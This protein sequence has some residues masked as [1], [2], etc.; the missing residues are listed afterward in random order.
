MGISLVSIVTHVRAG[1]P[2]HSAPAASAPVPEAA[3]P[4]A[5]GSLSRDAASA[6]GMLAAGTPVIPTGS[7]TTARPGT[8][9]ISS[10][11]V[12]ATATMSV[13]AHSSLHP[14]QFIAM[15]R[16][17]GPGWL[18]SDGTKSTR[19]PDGRV[20]WSYG[21]TLI[22]TAREGRVTRLDGFLRNSLV[23]QDGAKRTTI[24][25][26]DAA[27]KPSA[28]ILSP[29]AGEWYWPGQPIVDNDAVKIV[30]GRVRKTNGP[31]GWNFAGAGSDIVTLNA[32]DLSVRSVD[33]LTS[34]PGT[35]WGGNV[36]RDGGYLYMTGNRRDD[37]WAPGM[38]L[39]RAPQGN[40]NSRH[41]EFWNGRGWVNKASEAR[42]ITHGTE[43]DIYKVPGGYALL[44]QGFPFGTDMYVQNAE[45]LTGPWTAPRKVAKLPKLPPNSI[46][47]GAK[48]HSAFSE[49]GKI[50][51]S[52]NVNRSDAGMPGDLS[53]YRPGFLNI[54]RSVL[55]MP[56]R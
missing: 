3:V 35:S 12:R 45:R 31:H 55:A 28:S 17:N 2:G 24:Y 42:P 25:K 54:P 14:E 26:R 43:G 52:Y 44:T 27:G 41:M 48:A 49:G 50:L 32:S 47:Y 7:P 1:S 34:T 46:T 15:H 36:F 9:P 4:R 39:A 10:E 51:V 13:D 22:G 37:Q 6:V 8:K 18:S 53:E 29:H 21:D 20:L 5:G 33:R 11:Y 19:L 56:A 40:F 38:L 30:V 23:V 16:S